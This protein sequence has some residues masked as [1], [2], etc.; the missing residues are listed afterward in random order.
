MA[1]GSSDQ[2]IVVA[3]STGSIAATRSLISIVATLP[4]GHVV[5]PGLDRMAQSQWAAISTDSGHP[6][7]QLAQLLL[8]LD[9]TPD[10]V[11]DWVSVSADAPQHLPHAD[12]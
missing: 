7:Y 3:G 4:N 6:Q 8:Y 1:G 5:L 11:Q 12:G 2:L 10:E 9:M